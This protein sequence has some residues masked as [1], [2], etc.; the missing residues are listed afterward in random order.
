MTNN[1]WNRLSLGAGF[2]KMVHSRKIKNVSKFISIK[3]LSAAQIF[4]STAKERWFTTSNFKTISS[5]KFAVQP[6]TFEI[7]DEKNIGFEVMTVSI[8]MAQCTD[9]QFLST[10]AFAVFCLS[11]EQ[12]CCIHV[13]L[14]LPSL[15]A[16]SFQMHCPV[17]VAGHH[18]QLFQ[19]DLEG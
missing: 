13:L 18:M 1:P 8:I 11:T 14:N 15:A 12:V 19:S 9:W 10:L 17:N 5:F 4:G 16:S 6:Y 2:A 7:D 3:C